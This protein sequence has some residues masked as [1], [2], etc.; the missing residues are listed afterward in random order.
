MPLIV[1]VKT[2]CM[3]G[4]YVA[5]IS[6]MAGQ[7]AGFNDHALMSMTGANAPGIGLDSPISM[8]L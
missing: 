8:A 7:D 5:P 1:R 6:C 4:K 2:L 3:V